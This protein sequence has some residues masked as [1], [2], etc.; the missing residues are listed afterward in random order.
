[1]L[2][3]AGAAAVDEKDKRNQH[4]SGVWDTKSPTGYVLTKE[5]VAKM[6]HKDGNAWEV[7]VWNVVEDPGGGND[8][9]N[10]QSFPRLY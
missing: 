10:A 3:A 7:E 6:D 5:H 8:V 9:V 4:K 1:M 2:L